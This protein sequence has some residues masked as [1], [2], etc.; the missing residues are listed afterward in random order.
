M[1]INRPSISG[2][3]LIPSP[4]RIIFW[5][6]FQFILLF[7]FETSVLSHAPGEARFDSPIPGWI[8]LV[9]AAAALILSFIL[10]NRYKPGKREEGSR[11]L[12]YSLRPAS[13]VPILGWF[14]QNPAVGLMAQIISV[15]LFLLVLLAGFFGH[16]K[17][18]FNATSNLIWTLFWFGLSLFSFL[19][20]NPW[21]HLNPWRALYRWVGMGRSFPR[22]R[23][24]RTLGSWPALI[25][26]IGFIWFELS[27]FQSDEPRSLAIITVLYSAYLW[28][29]MFF[30]GEGWLDLGDPFTR[31]FRVLGLF[32]PIGR[33]ERGLE[34]RPCGAA[35]RNTSLKE[36]LD[37]AFVIGIMYSV[38]YDG[39][40]ATQEWIRSIGALMEIAIDAFPDMPVME[41]VQLV[42]LAIGLVVFIAAYWGS[43]AWMASMAGN[44]TTGELARAFGLSLLPIAFGYYLAHFFMLIIPRFAELGAA[45]SDPFGWKAA[46]APVSAS[47]P[48]SSGL[49]LKT[50]V[51]WAC[52]MVLIV[53]GHI[54]SVVTAHQ[55]AQR[56]LVGVR[57]FAVSQLPLLAL[58][59]LYTWVSLWIASRPLLREPLVPLMEDLLREVAH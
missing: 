25:L 45:L 55:V 41:G 22:I 36:N 21:D 23:Y 20:G 29:G 50:E 52:Q 28:M 8:V 32:A 53:M 37:V 56:A 2:K 31:Y 16:P 42:I 24:P 1:T 47:H 46:S 38:T 48:A 57:R 39:Y 12:R 44:K 3:C 7:L 51:I 26:Y 10:L 19:V 14:V 13:S 15:A 33:G 5:I 30:F 54:F 49:R 9:A 43:C 6:S 4:T 27:W 58:M 40:M 35:L 17:T 18:E 11:P 59:I 34:A